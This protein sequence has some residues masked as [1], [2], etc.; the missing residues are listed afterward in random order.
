MTAPWAWLARLLEA[1]AATGP[2]EAAG[3]VLTE[4]RRA[5]G[6]Q[7]AIAFAL[8]S[9]RQVPVAAV[10]L[11]LP[12]L[13]E[14]R[15]EGLPPAKPSRLGRRGVRP[16]L[17]RGL[18]FVARSAAAAPITFRGRALGSLELL[19]L[20]AGKPSL[21]A[22]GAAGAVLGSAWQRLAPTDAGPAFLRRVVDALPAGLLVVDLEGRLVSANQRAEHLLRLPLQGRETT[23]LHDLA[24][25]REGF[26]E[27]VHAVMRAGK[28]LT[29]QSTVINLDGDP[30][31]IGYSG[32]PVLG[33]DGATAGYA[34]LFQD[35]S[36]IVST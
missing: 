2:E 28:T 4:L 5:S 23:P 13:K 15:F 27:A 21:P 3:L 18:G 19:N 26:M 6:A 10:G 35:I 14:L 11:S 9:G 25:E 1:L 22:L 12:R 8:E 29:R 34:L 30:R 20:P 7:A 17:E 31:T 32:A 24:R 33:A 16:E 36:A